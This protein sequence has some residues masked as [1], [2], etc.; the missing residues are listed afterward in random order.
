MSLYDLTVGNLPQVSDVNQL[1]DMFSGKHDV[2]PITFAPALSAPSTTGYSLALQAG[3][4]L[5]IGAYN[6]Q[7]SLISGYYKTDG[8]L[9]K[10]GETTP[11]SSIALTTT[12]GNQVIKVTLP[13]TGFS[14]SAVAIGIY[15]TAV[16]GSTY[17][18]IAI[19][20]IGNATY[21][22]TTADGSRGVAPLTVN[23]TGT[24]L[25]A[26]LF[27]GAVPYMFLS[28][29][30]GFSIGSANTLI[31][32]PINVSADLGQAGAAILT[33]AHDAN[34][35]YISIPVGGVYVIQ[36]EF[37]ISGLNN[38]QVIQFLC[39]R[40]LSNGTYG[41][42]QQGMY[43]YSGLGSNYGSGKQGI[44]ITY[45]TAWACDAGSK[46]YFFTQCSEAPRTL[47]GYNIQVTKVG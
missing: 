39:R 26:P 8:T 9:Q 23:T 14:A 5:G 43:G 32:I 17:G 27:Y 34:G 29:A 2:G 1:V 45:Q 19:V 41:D 36:A 40:Y 15:R 16:G 30:S 21:T 7:F 37:W 47:N 44:Q 35:D 11:S 42:D 28:H 10:T 20:K 13:T 31:N 4:S 12:T 33:L 25:T 6:Y 46:L 22:D 3:T 38:L 18:L 24:S